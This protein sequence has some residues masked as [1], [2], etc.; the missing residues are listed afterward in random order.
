VTNHPLPLAT[1]GIGL[2]WLAASTVRGTTSTTRRSSSAYRGGP[3]ITRSYEGQLYGD[4]EHEG[5]PEGGRWRLSGRFDSVREKATAASAEL[6]QKAAGLSQKATD[7]SQ[8]AT[9]KAADLSQ[10]ASSV[11]QSASRTLQ[12]LRS[13][14][15]TMPTDAR[16]YGRDARGTI[17]GTIREQPLLVG[18]AGAL[19]GMALAALLPSTRI[20][21]DLLGGFGSSLTDDAKALADGGMETVKKHAEEAARDIQ[22]QLGAS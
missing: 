9:T 16:Q 21:Q 15:S 20:E 22:G 7:L 5:A 19:V 6:S 3:E 13:R 2:L 14:A 12:D 17:T 10:K 11:R 1:I 8:M 18:A 4:P